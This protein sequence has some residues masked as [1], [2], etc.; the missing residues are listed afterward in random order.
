MA[1]TGTGL[2]LEN[3]AR[4]DALIAIE[5]KYQKIWSE[6]HQFEVDAPAIT[7]KETVDM[8]SEELHEKY[9]KF[10]SSM[11]YPYMNGVLHA[12]HCFTLSKVEFSIGFERMNGKRA[13]FPLGF[14]C[15][16]MPILACADKLKREIE[17]FG[18]NF[19][20]LPSEEEEKEQELKKEQE[21]EKQN[22]AKEVDPTKFKAKKSKAQAKQG[23]GKYQFE[24]MMQ[25]GIE[26]E[27]VKKFADAAY[28]LN[29]FPAL[30]QEDC[31][32]IGAKV[33]WRRSF[34]TTD[35]NP[36]Y[37]AF[38]RWQM[39]KMKES[40]KIK[41]GERYTIY[42]EK[43]GQ[44]CMDH[45]RQSGEGITPQ[46]YVGIKIEATEL[47]ENAQKIVDSVSDFDKSKK[48]YFV[49]ATL[50]P[51]TMYGQTCCFVSPKIDYGIFDNGDSYY[52]TTERAYKNMSYQKITPQ[53]G[54]YK[55]VVTISGKDFIGTK[56]NPPLA[57]QSN[58]RILP[59][60]TVIATKGTG[61]VTCVPSNSP[62]DYMTLSDLKNK[63][64]YYGI[65][66]DWVKDLEVLP[67]IDTEKYG[68]L[69][70]KTLCEEMKIQ[71]PKD[72]VKLAEAKK[73]AYKEDYYSGVM[74]IGKYKG[75][76]VEVAKSKLKAD[77]IA[78]GTAF[79]YNEPEGLVISRSGDDCIVSLEDQWYVDY[80]EESWKA[81]AR[82][83]L[84]HM[85]LFAPEVKNAFEG[86]LNWLSNWAVSRSYGLGTKLPWDPKYLV[87]SLSDS[88]IYQAFYTIAHLLFTDYY[89][90]DVGPLG[91]KAEQMTDDVFDYIFQHKDTINTDIKME[92][93]DSLRREFEY[94]YPLD[95]SISG[96]DL[97]NNHLT[98]FIYTHVA[99]FP[100]K[101]WPKGIRANGHLM[102][103]NQKMSKS[104]GNF[105]TL[106]QIVEK[107][108]ADASRIALAD[109]GDTVEDA[110]FDESNANAAILRLYVL[111]DWA[112]EVLARDDLRTGEYDE[113]FDKGFDTEM[114]DIVEK[115]YE[116]YTLT[117][118]KNALKLGLFDFQNSRDYYRDSVAETGKGMHKDLV[119]KYI[120]TQ[121]L[122]LT[123]I[124]PHFCDYVYRE[125]LD[126]KTSIQNAKFPRASKPV[127]I[128]V[129]DSLNYVRGLQKSIRE[130]EGQA[131]KLKKGRSDVNADKD[132]KITVLVGTDFPEWQ[133][134]YLQVAKELHSE[135]T[136]NDN[137]VLKTKVDGKDMKK[138]MPFISK[139][140][141]RL[142]AGEQPE[143]VFNNKTTFNELELIEKIYKN[144][145]IKQAV[146]AISKDKI[147]ALDILAIAPGSDS[148]TS[149]VTKEEGLPLPQG[150]SKAI[151]NAVP[152]SPSV[153]IRNVE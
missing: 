97:I 121:A 106:K 36:Y 95:V 15:T 27:D 123:P 81:E 58:L 102:L 6:E 40:G 70:A 118:Y 50:R 46:E 32:S 2:V 93:L 143:V 20:N 78:D 3:T 56:I 133:N 11:A 108:G 42:S 68:N 9:P 53:R 62:D 113:I 98:F 145:S 13:L 73:I 55:P 90:K 153:I 146:Q 85:E 38:I 59:M 57:Q 44:A 105:M 117:N 109:A 22:N 100:K 82:E 4:R 101:F 21:K 52:I 137:S 34:I 131:L 77:M 125:L 67:I 33:D 43:D 24:I 126:N 60:E 122:L 152:G 86:T 10:M 35:V 63:S 23:R 72:S 151:E 140:K 64:A 49:A 51:E 128:S 29:Y 12:G 31:E 89:G 138:V 69:T 87:E 141:Q 144:D 142:A 132:V 114:D 99:L 115:T 112:E 129:I 8:T 66:N 14:H 47:A 130:T 65:D 127:D 83:C 134:K 79:V 148:A 88:T 16:G 5:K 80:G 54:Y 74:A 149:I 147:V 75:E 39:N 41:F 76:K 71:S 1:E 92:S 84:D 120:E 139:L 107:F 111:K 37:D 136:L 94:F 48:I 124:A 110:N 25:L 116:Q 7:D 26:K 104:T 96:K 17:M 45:D 103:N 61:V 19:E 30:C 28:W 119:L 135:G 91:I 150:A 18:E